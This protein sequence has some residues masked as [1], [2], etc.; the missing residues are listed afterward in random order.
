MK[1]TPWPEM[2][3]NIYNNTVKHWDFSNV[4]NRKFNTENKMNFSQAL[5]LIK[6]GK[7]LA[8]DGWNGKG[9]FVYLVHG[10]KFIVNR[11]P[12]NAMYKEG[13]EITYNP[14]IDI[15]CADGH[16]SVWAPSMGDVMAEDWKEVN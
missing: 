15:K 8:R 3:N 11:P 2:V 4:R 13:T 12:L 9:L 5:E 16:C 10:S 1:W 14:H 6:E 7:K